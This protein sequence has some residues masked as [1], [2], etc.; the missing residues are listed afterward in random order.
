MGVEASA[1]LNALLVFAAVAEAGGF[2]AAAERLGLSKARVSLEVSRLEARLGLSLFTRTTRRVQ[3]TEAGQTLID[4]CVPALRGV[5]DTL[6]GLG[7]TGELRGTLRI[8]CTV[9]QAQQSLAPAVAA[10]AQLHSRLQLELRSSDRV[11]DLVREGVDVAFRMGW[12][13]DST[14]RATRLGGFAQQVVAS[15]A[16]LRRAGQPQTPEDLARMD[17]VALTLL[18]TPLTWRFTDPDGA[19]RSVRMTGRLRC[20]SAATLR[21]LLLEGAGVSVMDRPSTE[22]LVARGELVRLLPQWSL[23]EGGIYA[24]YAPGRHV[25]AKVRAFIDFYQARLPQAGQ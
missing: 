7:R 19:Q 16:Y 4:E 3:L 18:P 25:A 24:V 13:R 8:A 11:V 6:A 2:T 12:L 17:W 15:P 14:L 23:P 22:A 5:Q 1:D 9:E 21:T 20:D 10:F